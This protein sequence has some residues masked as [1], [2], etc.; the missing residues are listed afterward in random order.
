VQDRDFFDLL[1][2]QWSKTSY[3]EHSFWGVA[4]DTEHYAEGPGT[5]IIWAEFKEPSKDI[6][7]VDG[8]KF[9]ASFNKEADAD[10][11]AGLHGCF[12]DLVRRWHDALSAEEASEKRADEAVQDQFRLATELAELKVKYGDK[13]EDYHGQAATQA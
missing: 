11:V 10:F 13:T 6:D 8:R 2:Q 1:Y 3:A 5:F 4:E 7:A 9:I 12:G